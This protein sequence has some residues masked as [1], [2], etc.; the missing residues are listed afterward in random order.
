MSTIEPPLSFRVGQF[1]DKLARRVPEGEWGITLKAYAAEHG[2]N[3]AY[4]TR[5]LSHYRLFV[6]ALGL[7]PDVFLLGPR[8]LDELRGKIDW[9][10][11]LQEVGAGLG[12]KW[13]KAEARRRVKKVMEGLKVNVEHRD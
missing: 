10:G 2:Y 4:V 13:G 8:K 9:D 5:S 3:T 7:G 1:L 6:K 11:M 12:G